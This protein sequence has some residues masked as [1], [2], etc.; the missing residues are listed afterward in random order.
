[1]FSSYPLIASPESDAV[2]IERE[3]RDAG[4]HH[5]RAT[6]CVQAVG[7]VQHTHVTTAVAALKHITLSLY[8]KSWRFLKMGRSAFLARNFCSYYKYN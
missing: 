2:E 3:S 1:M 7:N 6:G 4:P 8:E 5:T